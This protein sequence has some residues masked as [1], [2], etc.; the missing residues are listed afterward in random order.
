MGEAALIGLDWGSTSLRAW[1]YDE[2]GTVMAEEWAELG[3]NR[4]ATRSDGTRSFDAA[5]E[6]ICGA[7]LLSTGSVPVIAA[8][9]VGADHGWLPTRY[10]PLPVHLDA[11]IECPS[12][13]TGS[14]ARV[15]VVPGVTDPGPE[16]AVMRGEEVEL[17]GIPLDSGD[18]EV[19]LP[20]THAKWVRVRDRRIRSI[21]TYVTGELFDLLMHH[22]S[23]SALAVAD[24]TPHWDAFVR[25]LDQARRSRGNVLSALFTAR[26]LPLAHQLGTNK[27]ADY[28]S[29]LLIGGELCTRFQQA[30]GAADRQLWIVGSASL[31]DRYARAARYLGRRDVVVVTDAA[32]RGLWRAA[33]LAG[34]IFA[35]L[36]ERVER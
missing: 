13:L 30:P 34:L 4:L 32:S 35:P 8:G 11:S 5:F 33:H 7:W 6:Q 21:Q 9:M 20:G 17:L 23:L 1:L 2:S 16:H 12:L 22:S 28:L 25:G 15:H 14:S 27:V 26:A 24:A 19:V 29:G 10:R 3:V 31:T 36:P 18:H